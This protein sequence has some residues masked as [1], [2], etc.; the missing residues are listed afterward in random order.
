M[1]I[2]DPKTNSLRARFGFGD[3][4]IRSSTR[5]VPLNGPRDIF[6]AS[7]SQGA[8][9]CLAD[10]DVEKIRPHVPQWFRDLIKTR[11][12]SCFQF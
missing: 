12:W 8:D 4:S 1:L 10:I 7:I 2:R 6:Y 5:A 11:G 3:E 9:L